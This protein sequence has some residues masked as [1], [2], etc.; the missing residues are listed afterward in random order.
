MGF[1][2][3]DYVYRHH[4]APTTKSVAALSWMATHVHV[5]FGLSKKLPDD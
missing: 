2:I 5:D 3:G 1:F 4:H